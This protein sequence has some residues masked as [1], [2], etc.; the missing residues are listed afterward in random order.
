MKDIQ[1]VDLL[2]N[3]NNVRDPVFRSSEMFSTGRR[4]REAPVRLIS[5]SLGACSDPLGEKVGDEPTQMSHRL[6]ELTE[7]GVR[8]SQAIG[9]LSGGLLLPMYGFASHPLQ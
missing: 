3:G 7:L 8:D 4:F 6:I 5:L 2:S 1:P 9:R